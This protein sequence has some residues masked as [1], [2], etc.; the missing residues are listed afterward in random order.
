M[1]QPRH[2]VANVRRSELHGD[3]DVCVVSASDHF[4]FNPSLIWLP[5]GKRRQEDITFPLAP[6]FEAHGIDFVHGE[7][8]SLDLA[9]K[10]VTTTAGAYN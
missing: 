9:A 5:F 3:V 7:A 6:T 4:V 1:L 10:Q 2:E 8:T